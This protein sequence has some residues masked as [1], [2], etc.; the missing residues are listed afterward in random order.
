MAYV[1]LS[2]MQVDGVTV[3][4][5]DQIATATVDGWPTR[6]AYLNAGSVRWIADADLAQFQADLASGAAT[7]EETVSAP[8]RSIL[9]DQVAG[10]HRV[11]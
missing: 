6:D 7:F 2:R 1:A 8:D 11:R 4:R 9:A 10:K 3:D 5:G